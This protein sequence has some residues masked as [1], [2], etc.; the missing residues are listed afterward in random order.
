[1]GQETQAAQPAGRKASKPRISLKVK[2][3]AV[4]TFYALLHYR[5]LHDEAFEP[6]EGALKLLDS[7]RAEV[8]AAESKKR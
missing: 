6:P 3:E 5:M 8:V 2:K 4:D 7:L 1:M